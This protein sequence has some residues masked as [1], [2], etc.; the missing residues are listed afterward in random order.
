[1]TGGFTVVMS[2]LQRAASAFDA[3]SGRLRGLIPASGPAC[4]DGGGEIDGALHAVL[5]RIGSLNA[6]LTGAL[7]AHGRRLAQAHAN[8]AH[9][10]I[11][12]VQ[13]CRSLAAAL[14]TG[15]PGGDAAAGRAP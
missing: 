1:M 13:L 12:G 3:E 8:Y 6:S 10:E 4:P 15:Q 9:A 5:S 14:G 7:A 11:T 2:D